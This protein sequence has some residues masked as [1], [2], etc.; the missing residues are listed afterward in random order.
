MQSYPVILA[1]T[2]FSPFL[3]S[4]K[5]VSLHRRLDRSSPVFKPDKYCSAG[6]RERDRAENGRC[7]SGRVTPSTRNRIFSERTQTHHLFE[8]TQLSEFALMGD[9]DGLLDA[10]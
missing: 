7:E 8:S 9:A 2:P 6:P 1:K 4:Q 5:G 10:D 3:R